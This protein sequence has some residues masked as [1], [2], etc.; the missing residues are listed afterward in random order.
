MD[1]RDT[2]DGTGQPL[3]ASSD[4]RTRLG[5]LGTEIASLEAIELRVL[6]ALSAGQSP[7]PESSMQKVLNTELSQKLTHLG[8]ELAGVYSAPFQPHATEI[9]G[10]IRELG[11]TADNA[12]AGPANTWSA[13]SR[14]LND[15]AG[16]IYAGTNEIQRNIM[17]K[18][19]LKI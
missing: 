10:R 14:Y 9:G 17:A 1:R 4:I 8:M 18:S 7:G 11:V 2:S 3:I 15:R 12:P 13:T 6:S 5:Q 16:S 19:V